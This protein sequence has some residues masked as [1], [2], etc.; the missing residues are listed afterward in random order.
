[1][2]RPRGSRDGWVACDLINIRAGRFTVLSVALEVGHQI[3]LASLLLL[4]KV[5][6]PVQTMKLTGLVLL[7]L[8]PSVCGNIGP[9]RSP[10]ISHYPYRT[11]GRSW[12]LA[13]NFCRTHHTDLVTIRNE[14][15]NELLSPLGGWIGLYRED[16]PSPW[17]WSE[18]EEIASFIPWKSGEP[19][20]QELCA[21][22]FHETNK[23]EG[24]GCGAKHSFICFDKKLVLVKK[25]K[26][27][28]EALEYCRGME[29]L[30]KS[31]PALEDQNHRFDLITL[32]TQDDHDFA[33]ETI[34]QA[35]SRAVWTGLRYLAGEWTW[36]GGEGVEYGDIADCPENVA[37]CGVV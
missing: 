28:E 33:Q 27:W 34:Q 23:W 22:K 37:L 8:L 5:F 18:G 4:P 24:D 29:A 32:I 17:K 19:L 1:M 30:N 25:S 31:K 15:E 21:F 3:L 20:I 9:L 11:Y 16:T 36:V 7:L 2:G 13:Q 12:I 6:P 14:E 35:S 26:T 10:M